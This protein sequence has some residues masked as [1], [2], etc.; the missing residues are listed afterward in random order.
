M[1]KKK[2]NFV[3]LERPGQA[4]A[5]ETRSLRRIGPTGAVCGEEFSPL[6]PQRLAAARS[7]DQGRGTLR[8]YVLRDAQM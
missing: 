4:T 2:G 8:G 7:T 1:T 6:F 3:P 5:V